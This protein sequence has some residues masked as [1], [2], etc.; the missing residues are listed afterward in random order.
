V[1]L[2]AGQLLL[3]YRLDRKIG[4]G[5]MGVVWKAVDTT[6]DREVA[7]KVLPDAFAEDTER[8]A[9][10]EREA[11]LLAS[12]N[13][14]NIATV[15][16][17]HETD[18]VRFLAM[19]FVD[20]ED[21]AQRLARGA[22]PLE[23]ALD[24]GAQMAEALETAHE[25]GVIH[26]DLKPAN[27]KLT[28]DGKVKVLDFGL[29]KALAPDAAAQSA[30]GSP[31]MSP[32]VTSVGTV[33]G[34]I[35]GT[36]SYMSPE[37]ARGR[38]VDR[39]ADIWSFGV[40]L[41]EM[42]TGR[43]MFAGDTVSDTLAEVLKVDP[44]WNALPADTP[45]AVRRLLR[46]CLAKH[47]KQRLHD[48]ADARLE[49]EEARSD[50]T[51]ET[52]RLV[53]PPSTWRYVHI[54]ATTLLLLASVVL[55]LF[56]VRDAPLRT[57][58][59]RFEI[60]APEGAAFYLDPEIPGPAV[61]SP[62]GRMVAF[63]A[64]D[65]EGQVRLY[66]RS[67]DATEARALAGT[68]NAYFPFWSPESDFVGFFANRKLK[69]V[70]VAGG[71]SLILCDAPTGRGASWSRDGVIV[72]AP[73][74]NTPLH[75]VSDAGGESTP[76]TQLDPE[77]KDL[78]H[79]FPHFLPD[80]GHFLYLVV[81]ALGDKENAV[82]VRALQGGEDEPLLLSPAQATYASGHLLFLDTAKRTLM[83]QP[84]D[85]KRLK[86]S[87]EALPVA[88]NIRLDGDVNHAVFSASRNGVLVYQV[89]APRS[90]S[91]LEWFD[92]DGSS[93]GS[94]GDPADYVEVHLS[95]DDAHVAVSINAAGSRD[96]WVY[97]IARNTPARFTFG[98]VSWLPCWSPDSS[99]L[100]FTSRRAGGIGLYRKSLGGSGQETLLIESEAAKFAE[101]WSPDGAFLAFD[102]NPQGTYDVWILPLDGA[103]EPYPF[104][105]TRFEDAGGEFSPDG[106]WLAYQST[107]SGRWEV[108]VTPFPGPGRKW[109]VSTGGGAWPQW[110]GD[111]K[112]IFYHGVDGRLMAVELDER[113]GALVAG[114]AE[115][116]FDISEFGHFSTYAATRDG[117]RFLVVQPQKKQDALALTLVVNWTAE[118][119]K[120]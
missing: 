103:R 1:T 26:R 55:A 60:P 68:D 19:E 64:R 65:A 82:F 76:I 75:R 91:R 84:F 112:E 4:E 69:K 30:D 108:Y 7:I 11:K 62:N 14:A 81:S 44:D 22:I 90:G 113:D 54:G 110:R 86:L 80:G 9:R 59:M 99:E 20:G 120:E 85:P 87:G 36:A 10:F 97:D 3:H 94:L 25:A 21:L 33:A 37:Q 18:G 118:F 17:V 63:S 106:R 13:H 72:F 35:L 58:V 6:L 38:P 47:P 109:Q 43:G 12:L 67:L 15:H 34:M 49:I 88:E 89:A 101:S 31:S 61:V 98:P 115:A 8:L 48:I 32:T 78:S 42:L 114:P 16:S 45:G 96:V 73:G 119:E 29:A 53:R 41:Y 46:R 77:R 116:L 100:V 111:G 117:R 56:L 5:G 74:G 66:V 105:Q 70:H 95:P 51:G 107:E 92:R 83:T 24:L 23:E 104:V 2:Q 40:V 52:Q 50:A 28:P 102:Q 79:R 39:R 27:I 93:E 71:T 57:T